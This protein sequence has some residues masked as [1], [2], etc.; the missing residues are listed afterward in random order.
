MPYS[1]LYIKAMLLISNR[2]H[3]KTM[4]K[5][6]TFKD[7]EYNLYS[8][9]NIIAG[10]N[11]TGKTSFLLNILKQYKQSPK[12]IYYYSRKDAFA[13]FKY[14]LKDCKYQRDESGIN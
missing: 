1:K 13:E 3:I 8:N 4:I 2:G 5:S 10:Q 9:V 11:G 6:I 7:K 14:S 12:S